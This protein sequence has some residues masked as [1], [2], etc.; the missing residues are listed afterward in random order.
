M[1][2]GILMLLHEVT[3]KQKTGTTKELIL[4]ED[5]SIS[6]HL[7]QKDFKQKVQNGFA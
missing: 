2:N 6:K 3:R 1:T 5:I 4:S 7:S